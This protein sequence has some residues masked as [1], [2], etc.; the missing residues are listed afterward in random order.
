MSQLSSVSLIVLCSLFYL[1]SLMSVYLA[2]LPL[3]L[4][5]V[6]SPSCAS[7]LFPV[8]VCFSAVFSF[9]VSYVSCVFPPWSSFPVA[10]VYQLLVVMLC[11]LFPVFEFF[12]AQ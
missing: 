8:P 10:L 6:I 7:L 12:T 1:E 5:C 9:V 3:V 2:L 11:F 4:L